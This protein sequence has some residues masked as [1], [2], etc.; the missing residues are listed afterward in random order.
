MAESVSACSLGARRALA[1]ANH[2]L[3]PEALE[4]LPRAWFDVLL[5][6][7]P[8]IIYEINRRWLEDV[9]CSFLRTRDASR[10]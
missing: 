10:A 2:T 1:Y 7:H 8:Q 9:R 5:R 6:R 4:R 3:L